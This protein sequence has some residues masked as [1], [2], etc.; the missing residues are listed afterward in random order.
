MLRADARAGRDRGGGRRLAGV[1]RRRAA[2]LLRRPPRARVR[3]GAQ[4]AARDRHAARHRAARGVGAGHAAAPSRRCALLAVIALAPVVAG[5]ARAGAYPLGEALRVAWGF[6]TP[7]RRDVLPLA[8]MFVWIPLAALAVALIWKRAA[9]AVPSPRSPSSP[10]DLSAAGMGQN[11][12]IPVAHAKPPVTGAMRAIGDERFV[13]RRPLGLPP[14]T[15][16]VA[17]ALRPARRPRLRLPDGQALRRP[18][19][20]R[21]HAARPARTSRCRARRRRRVADGVAG[22]GTARPSRACCSRRRRTLPLPRALRGPGRRRLREPRGRAARVRRRAASASSTTSS[23]RSP[24]R[25]STRARPPSSP[26]RSGCAAAASARVIA[27]EPERVV[28]R[29]RADDRAAARPRRHLVPGLEGEGR[30]PRRADRPHATTCC[31]AS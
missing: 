9:L 21:R 10:S 24:R 26:R 2:V 27:D 1:V 19:A 20:A 28:I 18:V 30:R 13:G 29:A 31:A 11:P 12:A 17:H 5:L 3:A 7:T 25:T 22:A 14:L 6:A 4:H 15:A 8:S 23:P 16:N